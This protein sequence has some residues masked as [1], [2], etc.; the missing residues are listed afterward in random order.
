MSAHGVFS[1]L[2]GSLVVGGLVAGLARIE[3]FPLSLA[4]EWGRRLEGLSPWRD[5]DL[6][7]GSLIA[8]LGREEPDAIRLLVRVGGE[9]AA[10]M[11]VRPVWLRG[12]Y[13]QLLAVDPAF[14]G[15]GL[16]TA[17]LAWVEGRAVQ[18]KA[19]NLWIA[20]SQINLGAQRLYERF[21]FERVSLLEDLV[22]DGFAEI[23][24]RKRTGVRGSSF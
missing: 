10:V 22:V 13:V 11:C 6:Q 2:P 14:Q 18:A 15:M 12:P 21:G 17:C 1:D 9:P 5:Y 20:A 3:V 19:R 8:F 16:G 7:S 4:P 24:Y 23:L